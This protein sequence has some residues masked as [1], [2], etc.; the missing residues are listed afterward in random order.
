MFRR[1]VATIFLP[2]F[3]CALAARAEKDPSPKLPALNAP[4]IGVT[5]YQAGL[6]TLDG[7]TLSLADFKGKVLFLHYWSTSCGYCVGKL[8]SIQRLWNRME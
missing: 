8:P 1:A 5:H 6:L 4:A 3:L 2:L 7:Q